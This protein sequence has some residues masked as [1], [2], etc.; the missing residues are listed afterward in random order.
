MQVILAIIRLKDHSSEVLVTMNTPVFISEQSAAAG[1]VG[2]GHKGDH[3]AAPDLFIKIL[4]TFTIKD[5]GLF[6]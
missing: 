1:N 2:A 4:S 3:L 6:G 5:Y